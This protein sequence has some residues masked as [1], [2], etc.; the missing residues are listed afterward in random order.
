M[1]FTKLFTAALC[2]SML[3]ASC[4]FDGTKGTFEEDLKAK[5]E[6]ND[7]VEITDGK[8]D[9]LELDDTPFVPTKDA[10]GNTIKWTLKIISNYSLASVDGITIQKITGTDVKVAYGYSAYAG[11]TVELDPADTTQKTVLITLTGSDAPKDYMIKA[12]ATVVKAVN[13]AMLDTDGDGYWGEAEDSVY[14]VSATDALGYFL[15]GRETWSLTWISRQKLA[16]DGITPVDGSFE[17]YTNTLDENKATLDG[18]Y[19]AE[20]YDAATDTWSKIATQT[21]AAN[22]GVYSIKY[23]LSSYVPVRLCCGEL[24]KVT[25]KVGTKDVNYAVPYTTKKY[26]IV[27]TAGVVN[28]TGGVITATNN[29]DGYFS[30]SSAETSALTVSNKGNGVIEISRPDYISNYYTDVA[31]K[32][33]VNSISF[34]KFTTADKAGIKVVRKDNTSSS[35]KYIEVAVE[36][37]EIVNEGKNIR[38]TLADKEL[39]NSEYNSLIILANSS[40]TFECKAYVGSSATEKSSVTLNLG[41]LAPATSTITKGGWLKLKGTL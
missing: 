1:K 22:D 24:S 37:V 18:L 8:V 5:Y 41:T 13:G 35:V 25:L 4:S 15:T 23:D 31:K 26:P 12:D 29:A 11:T 32:N 21:P 6:N 39:S 30:Q 36:A 19:W 3:L 33:T 17:F 9:A 34:E 10:E 2:G 14:E 38:I 27:P 28:V 40:V 16:S 7:K 20:S